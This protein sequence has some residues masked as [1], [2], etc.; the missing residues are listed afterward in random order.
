MCVCV[1]MHLYVCRRCSKQQ[2]MSIR[3]AML[4]KARAYDVLH[5]SS[6]RLGPSKEAAVLT[7][8]AQYHASIKPC[9]TTLHFTDRGRTA[10][11]K[12]LYGC[13]CRTTR[14]AIDGLAPLC[15][16]YLCMYCT[17]T[18]GYATRACYPI[19]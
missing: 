1:C 19:P 9:I 8:P 18:L 11:Q 5:G 17:L 3:G 12:R 14:Q 2:Q 13:G 7:R 10:W 4:R 6:L 16:L 15:L